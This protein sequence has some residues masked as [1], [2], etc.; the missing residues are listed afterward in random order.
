MGILE[1]DEPEY[2]EEDG[3]ALV[4]EIRRILLRPLLWKVLQ[5]WKLEKTS[6]EKSYKFETLQKFCCSTS[7]RHQHHPTCR[8]SSR[9]LVRPPSWAV[10][11]V[12]IQ[13][14]RVHGTPGTP[15][16]MVA[17]ILTD[18]WRWKVE[19]FRWFY[20]LKTDQSFSGPAWSQCC[21]S[22]CWKKKEFKNI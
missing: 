21:Q 1:G 20:L 13:E 11:R 22:Q 3:K 10:R 19:L 8:S 17:I 14:W 12:R 2:G 7:S 4:G 6:F 9:M 18:K 16:I 5:I 15:R